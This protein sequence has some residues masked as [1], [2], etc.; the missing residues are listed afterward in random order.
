MP[1]QKANIK[2]R[3][4]PIRRKRKGGGGASFMRWLRALP[5]WWIAAVICFATIALFPIIHYL[6]SFSFYLFP[7]SHPSSY[8]IRGIDISHYQESINW[9]RLRGADMDDEPVTFVIIKATEGADLKDTYFQHNIQEARKHGMTV[10][11]YHFLTPTATAQAQA[12]FFI[13]LVELQP[14]DLPPVL[15]IEDEARWLSVYEDK[16]EIKRIALEWLSIVERHYGVR[17]I[18]YSSLGFR[19]N[20]LDDTRFDAYPF[21]MAHYYVDT[22]SQDIPW[23]FWQHTD[24]GRLPGIRGPVDCNVFRGTADDFEE[25]LLK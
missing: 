3:R 25:L 4:T 2:P 5:L 1:R 22:P 9:K 21:W 11:A 23:T 10:G 24:R 20:L 16:S 8:T 13:E 15:D 14:G 7:V 19:R 18:L 17:P 6:L 12:K